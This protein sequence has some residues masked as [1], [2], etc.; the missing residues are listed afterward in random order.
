ML[1]LNRIRIR[2]HTNI[3]TKPSCSLFPIRSTAQLILRNA[4]AEKVHPRDDI[5]ACKNN[6]ISTFSYSYNVYK[7]PH[8]KVI[9]TNTIASMGFIFLKRDKSTKVVLAVL[10]VFSVPRENNAIWLNSNL[11]SPSNECLFYD[12]AQKRAT[13]YRCLHFF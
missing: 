9:L 7:R 3:C 4:N 10:L 11:H 1:N 13:F 6:R 5:S 12:R 8:Y 2:K